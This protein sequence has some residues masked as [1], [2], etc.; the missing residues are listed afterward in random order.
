MQLAERTDI[1][2]A[3]HA[4][5]NLLLA[6]HHEDARRLFRLIRV[7]VIQRRCRRQHA[8]ND[9]NQGQLADERVGDGLKH[10]R[11]KAL[12][13]VRVADVHALGLGVDAVISMLQRAG[14]IHGQFIHQRAHTD[15]VQTGNRRNRHDAALHRP[16]AAYLPESGFLGD[17]CPRR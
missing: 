2:C 11:G 3:E 16:A 8:G 6:A 12:A 7:R 1:A 5:R 14:H 17:P 10:L 9:L 4:D 13:H 15:A